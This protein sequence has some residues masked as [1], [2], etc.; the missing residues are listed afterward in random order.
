MTLFPPYLGKNEIFDGDVINAS[1]E[2]LSQTMMS[3]RLKH[4]ILYL[5]LYHK[6]HSF[7]HAPLAS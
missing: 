7:F 5:A 3:P 4:E 2:F 1:S 6:Q